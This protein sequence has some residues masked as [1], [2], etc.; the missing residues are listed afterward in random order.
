MSRYPMHM[1]LD[2]SRFDQVPVLGYGLVLRNKT[3]KRLERRSRIRVDIELPET[4]AMDINDYF[5]NYM[6][7]A[8]KT[9]ALS[10]RRNW[11]S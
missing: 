8:A 3:M 2:F 5:L 1:N 9:S 7:L 4:S 10:V 6:D 11:F